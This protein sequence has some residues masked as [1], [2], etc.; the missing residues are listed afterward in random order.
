MAH[1]HGLR[2]NGRRGDTGGRRVISRV[3]QRPTESGLNNLADQA[4][5][6][7]REELLTIPGIAGAVF[8]GDPG[9]PAGVKVQLAPGADPEEVGRRVRR[10]LAGHGMR[11]QLTAPAVAPRTPPPPPGPRTV[12]NISDFDQSGSAPG[13]GNDIEATA[14]PARATMPDGGLEAVE[15]D[16]RDAPDPAEAVAA[17]GADP[18]AV[19]GQARSRA[20]EVLGHVT[21][22]QDGTGVAV[23][24]TAG[25][26]V[27]ERRAVASEGGMDQAILSA[28]CELMAVSPEPAL[29]EVA[30]TQ[31]EGASVI[32]VLVDDGVAV[33]AGSAVY[34]GNRSWAVARAIWSAVSGPA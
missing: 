16:V 6:S 32:S 5:R 15:G 30:A 18:S 33:R 27:A 1:P 25:D 31:R 2:I 13:G 20:V 23:V 4:R 3:A 28:V 22:T 21:V 9:Q 12:I 34:R 24:V 8:E 26:R 17:D 11:S 19:A 7:I 10:V 29:V 14:A